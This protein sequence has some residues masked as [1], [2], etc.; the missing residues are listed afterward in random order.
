MGNVKLAVIGNGGRGTG[1]VCTLASMKDVDLVAVCDIYEDRV[2]NSK[3]AAED[4]QGIKVRAYTDYKKMIADGDIDGVVIASSWESHGY[5]AAA[6]LNAGI[7]AAVECGGA[8]S[9]DECWQI[10]R[11]YERTGAHC[12]FLENCC[13]GR[14]EM[15]LLRMIKEGMFGEIVHL[16]GGYEHDLRQEV[17]FGHENRH[18]RYD[19][20]HYR[21]AELYPAHGLGPMSKYIDINRGNRMLT[22]VS[23]ASKARGLHEYIV[24][25]KGADSPYAKADIK[26][27]DIVNTLIKCANGETM[28]LTH[29]TTLPRPYSRA[30]RIQGTKG[31]WMEDKAALHLEGRSEGE[32]WESFSN[33]MDDPAF[34][35]PLWTEYRALGVDGGHGGMDYLVLRA[36]IECVRERT[37][38]PLDAYDAATLMAITV[39]SEQSI[40]LG[41]APVAIPDFT[42][43]KWIKRKSDPKSKYSLDTVHSDLF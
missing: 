17:S 7:Y 41:S 40:A 14:E 38:P 33:Y 31:L 19:N 24:K 18:Y 13:Y 30:G 3:K 32:S 6:C 28:L 22:L 25:N 27:G 43:G 1:H 8:C 15:T 12:M 9:I 23:M 37:Q 5:T 42:D 4:I 39:L 16:Q 26:Q 21:C 2:Q 35:H 29:D 34:E 20:Y 10:V 11:A 36:F